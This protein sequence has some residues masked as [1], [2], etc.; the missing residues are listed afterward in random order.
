MIVR[1]PLFNTWVVHQNMSIQ[2]LL[3]LLKP[4]R[5]T[6]IVDIGANPVDGE[7]PYRPMLA[8]KNLCRLT[9]FEPQ[10]D[11]LDALLKK[12]GQN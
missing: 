8:A 5:L 2:N 3:Q 10:Q 1:D 11:A 6:E 12:K 9:G 4:A 7:P